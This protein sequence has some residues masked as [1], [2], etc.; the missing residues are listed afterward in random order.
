[1]PDATPPDDTGTPD[2]PTNDLPPASD[3]PP[4][5]LMIGII[6]APH[7]VNGAMRLRIIS[8]F[9]ERLATLSHVYIGDDPQRRR[10]RSLRGASP[11][12]VLEINGISSRNEAAMLRGMPLYMDIRDAKPLDEGEYYW[13]QLIDLTVV[14]PEGTTLGILT[15]ILQTGANDVYVVTQP[16]GTELLLPAIKAIVLDIDLPNKRIVAKPLEYL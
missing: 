16:D 3:A 8:D 1:M 9:P 4:E 13:H 5:R 10:L 6:G 11:T 12:A 15:S 2:V 14:S 7:G